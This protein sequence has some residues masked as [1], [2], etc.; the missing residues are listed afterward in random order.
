MKA[1]KLSKE[2]MKKYILRR[3][4]QVNSSMRTDGGQRVSLD[5]KDT[6]TNISDQLEHVSC[7][8]V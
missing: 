1:K 5:Y 7:G 8:V 3:K 6:I 4:W 2:R